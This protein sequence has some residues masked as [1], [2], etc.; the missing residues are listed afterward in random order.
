MTI[1]GAVRFSINRV[2]ISLI[3]LF[4]LIV[5]SLSSYAANPHL[6]T[7]DS[8]QSAQ[9]TGFQLNSLSDSIDFSL[10][11]GGQTVRFDLQHNT[12]LVKNL[13]LSVYPGEFTLYRGKIQGETDS[14][15]RFTDNNGKISGAYFDGTN[16]FLVDPVADIQDSLQDRRLFD[17]NDNSLAV[18][19]ANSIRHSGLCA[20]EN[21]ST[22]QA[23]DFSQYTHDLEVMTS[24]VAGKQISVALVAD[25]EYSTS[26]STNANL[27]MITEMN[28]VDAIFSEQV[29]VQL[30]IV[31]ST[32]LDNNGTLTS[33]DAITLIEAFG[34][35]IRDTSGNPGAA[36][37]FTGK[38]LNGST[39]GIAYVG[40]LCNN[41]A[42]GVTQRYNAVTALVA[43]HEFGHNFGS[44]HDNQSGSACASTNGT[45]LM[46]PSINGSDQ[47]SACSLEQ[48][49]F[50]VNNASCIID[51][52]VT[53]PTIESSPS[54][55]GAVG[56]AYA[57][58]EDNQLSA[59]GAG[60]VIFSLDFGPDGMTVSSQGDVTWTPT[61][62]QVGTNSVQITAVNAFGSDT[63]SFDI[64]VSNPNN[65]YINFFNSDIMAYGRNQDV[66]GIVSVED[67]GATLNIQGNS[68]KSIALPYLITA[69][70][71][72]EFDFQSSMQGEIHGIG[73][74]IDENY[75][76]QRIFKIFGTQT[77]GIRQFTYSGSGD[78][79]HFVIP[80]GQFYSGQV[81]N[82][83]FVMDNDVANPQSESKFSFV[84]VY[85]KNT[86]ILD[87]NEFDITDFGGNQSVTGYTEIIE[88][89]AGIRL[90][91][92]I[93]KKIEVGAVVTEVSVL[94]F[95]F[96]SSVQGEI[97]GIGLINSDQIKAANNFQ[98]FGSQKWGN[99]DFTY[100]G[101]GEYQKFVIPI[102]Q[103]YTGSNNWLFFVMDQD[104]PNPNAESMFRNIII[105]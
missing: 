11:V 16:L 93:W 99:R 76:S 78:V 66:Q 9:P 34:P 22:A 92:N 100:T 1:Y 15:A 84:K 56:V 44:P 54:L 30:T 3:G 96:K 103:Y 46:N 85:E 27:E 23:F 51:N 31:S 62:E 35:Y 98:V 69:S 95:E 47:F 5:F 105:R 82:L 21:H 40:A 75:E 38:N 59:S 17:R 42:V 28:V 49:S 87:F 104:I 4:L 37:L 33:T 32:V 55:L 58:D 88:N 102:G 89:G 57:Y 53:P 41:Y 70:T 61:S 86:D 24:A 101:N 43:A 52:D 90:E 71:V 94:E 50:L 18:Y 73:M 26:S 6:V 74:D 25:V 67:A 91:G 48:M 77:F 81:N 79:E 12:A 60:S 29:G 13:D 72:L 64:E 14:W 97:H 68:W 63:Q 45:F 36:H 39:I 2:C 80:I 83:F 19:N 20:L 65:E 10:Q 8:A 7:I